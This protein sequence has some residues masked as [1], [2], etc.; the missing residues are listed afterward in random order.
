MQAAIDEACA[1][2]EQ[3][4]T[5]LRRGEFSFGFLH[6]GIGNLRL[7]R[8]TLQAFLQALVD[9]SKGEIDASLAKYGSLEYMLP[10]N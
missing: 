10:K 5:I 8:S 1:F 7:P 6:R 9:E 2:A 3:H 4:G